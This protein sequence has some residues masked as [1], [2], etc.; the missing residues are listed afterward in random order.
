MPFVHLHLH[1]EY[2]LLDG[3]CRICEI[4]RRAKELGQTAVAL[5]D[6]GVMYG[7]VDFYRACREEGIRPIIGC[8]LYLASGSRFDK[9]HG[10]DGKYS[11]LVLLCENET[12][13]RNLIYLVSK[14]FTEGF[15]VKP[16]IDEELLFSHK[17]G[18]IA[19]SAC[20]SGK[21][22]RMILNGDNEGAEAFA[23]RMAKEFGKDRFYL[24]LQDHG[25][26]GQDR[27]NSVI[28]AIGQRN[29]IPLV[30]TNDVHYLKKEDAQTHAVLKCIQTNTTID[31]GRPEAFRTDEFYMKSGEEMS[32][33]FS[34][35]PGAVENTGKIASMC[36]FSFTFGKLHLPGYE[37]PEGKDPKKYLRELAFAGLE[38]RQERGQIVFTDDR[39]QEDYKYRIEYEL[40]VIGS[41]GYAEYFL[42]VADFVN[43]A[44]SKRIPTG[45]GRGSGAG[46]LVAYLI[47]ITEVDPLKYNLLF[48]S[49]LNPERVSMPDFDIDFGDERRDEVIRY[50][51]EKY[52]EDHVSQIVT[53]GTMAARAAVR[54]VGRA[55]GMPYAEVD[56]VAKLIPQELKITLS[57]ALETPEL[58]AKVQ[59][60]DRA[61]RLIRI[62]MAVE[63]MPRHASTHA[64][65]VVITDRPIT[66]HVPVAMNGDTPVTQFDM[67]TI[68]ALGLLK[69]DFLALRYLT[70]IDE[71]VRSVKRI[72]PSFDFEHL[73]YDDEDAFSLISSGETDGLFQLESAGIK[74]ML[75]EFRPR[76]VEDIMIAIALYRPGPM[77]AIPVFL[78]NRKNPSQIRYPVDALK[79]ILD[80]T[81]G[82]IVYQE[83]VMQIFRAVAGY[84]YGKADVVRR[85]ISKKKADVIEKERGNFIAGAVK[86][87]T[88]EKIATELFDQMTD[89]ADY[90][91]KKS[92]AAAYALLSYQT[93]YLKAHF[94]VCYYAALLSSVLGN[95]AKMTQYIAACGKKNI[96]VLPP[97]INASGIR[98]TALG[99]S[100]R[101]GLLAVKNI[102][103]GFLRRVLEERKNG[104]FT[105][106]Y[107]FMS[108]LSGGE[109]NRRQIETLIMVGAFDSLGV[110]RNR[111]LSVLPSLAEMFASRSGGV[112]G[113][114]DLFAGEQVGFSYPVLP[115]L[116]VRDKLNM[117][118]EASDLYFSG[119]L[120]D[121]FGDHIA[122]LRSAEIADIRASFED[123]G[124]NGA[125]REGQTVTV[126]GLISRRVSK[127]TKSG[128]PMAF[129]TLD[130]R[131]SSI[132]V[133]VFPKIL[134][135]KDGLL[136]QG[137]AICVS[138]Q[139]SVREE[140]PPR[141][142]VAAAYPLIPNERFHPETFRDP[143]DLPGTPDVRYVPSRSVYGSAATQPGG[144]PA[145]PSSGAAAA[146]DSAAVSYQT[147]RL[148]G[149]LTEAQKAA[150]A[151]NAPTPVQ[152]RPE[153]RTGPGYRQ[154]DA[155]QISPGQD[156]V[157][158]VRVP[159]MQGKIFHKALN[160]IEIFCGTTPVVFYDQ[161]CG[162][163]LKYN[164]SADAIP[165]LVSE[166]DRLLGKGSAVL[167]NKPKT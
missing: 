116:S 103:G 90:G 83:Q 53:F 108:R 82:C 39:K 73:P 62:S 45:P 70:V 113:Q 60:D 26:E 37:L 121:S 117:E 93:A 24:E 130:D 148:Q 12:G 142:L 97:D 139:I 147:Q 50:V 157:L 19:L 14:G 132:E 65:G 106:F 47:G 166:L 145:G 134:E 111:L 9:D 96:S 63:G 154:P 69:F 81:S 163:Y 92:H 36:D 13:Y 152:L 49:F 84:S 133:I 149:E 42:I 94:P 112:N 115:P 91:F 67:D 124:E 85:A 71:T 159:D 88:D 21:I 33:L 78:K 2:S 167:R 15:Y 135:G 28:A 72:D 4:P 46:S 61:A 99:N 138:G 66:E 31:A 58:K 129:L 20:L 30:C 105:S 5:T 18:L 143:F 7:A 29:G 122:A 104:P 156:A 55:L 76:S 10:E 101:F 162:K 79:P 118:K 3:A 16:R 6:H 150:H 98:F 75:T 34:R 160:L 110:E 59:S 137:A 22:P 153:E 140:E 151:K 131:Y 125:F 165:Y 107:E 11:H 57:K 126:S 127:E 43:Y 52:G 123:D 41:M 77:D 164:H 141:L 40:V 89:F 120:L 74:R 64:A 1:S 35:F 100:I 136:Q 68:A 25:I 114:F 17:E 32:S 86:N 27:V 144:Q 23:V 56:A 119:H 158:Y 128:D 44:K 102:G 146:R 161:S 48:E 51:S 155:V 95:T 38:K 8:E 54:D 109:M 80:E 87:G